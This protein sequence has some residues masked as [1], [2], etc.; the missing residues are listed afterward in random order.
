MSE[1]DVDQ[2]LSKVEGL[3][4]ASRQLRGDIVK[5]LKNGKIYF[6]EET[7][8]ILK[9]H[10][11]YQQDDR[12]LRAARRKAGEEK[13]YSMMIRARI[14]GG[15]LSSQA[16]LQFDRLSQT[17]GNQ[18]L[19]VTTRQTFQIHGV[20]KENI[21]Q[22]IKEINDVMIT[23]LGGCGDQVRNTLLCP[24][25]H[26]GPLH[27]Q[28]K[29]H[30]Y[31]LVDALSA[32]TKAYH[33]IWLDGEK[34]ASG[35]P[36]EE[37]LYGQ[38]YLP[39]KFKLAI[40]IEG[41]NCVD[42]YANDL[43]I[44][45]HRDGDTLLGYTLLVGGGMGRN[46][47]KAD[48]Y[49][50]A[51]SPL[52]FVTPEQLIDA[53]IAIVSIQRDHGNRT[54]RQ[55]SRFKYLIDKVGLPWFKEELERRLGTSLSEPRA[56]HFEGTSD[57]LGW[58]AQGD[59]RFALG[60]FIENGRIIDREGFQIKTALREIMTRFQPE[61]HLTTSQNLILCDL[62]AQD[63]Q[64]IE[65]TLK[66]YGVK[67]TEEITNVRRFSM[68]CPSMPTCGLAIAESERALP[69]LISQIEQVVAELSLQEERFT[70]RMTGCPNGCA[71]PYIGDIGLVG[72]APG[73]YDV[74]L[75]G[76]FYGTHLNERFKETV[77]IQEIPGLLRTLLEDFKVHR[78][79]QEMFGDYCARIGIA[80]LQER[81]GIYV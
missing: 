29:E 79:A 63:R 62:E 20:L 38:T 72:R 5:E 31:Q 47:T 67:L 25:P 53:A 23:T 65:A 56:L 45:A 36:D 7:I 11:M 51:A 41:D 64:E 1:Q 55:H 70:I 74:Y 28:L 6:T 14:P 24:F 10:G 78:T 59:G 32:K 61:I 35:E 77:P 46:H 48:T 44:V 18:T 50:R 68:A 42:V 9:F 57:H 33:E 40:A 26:H 21:K 39:R 60:I 34:I 27:D 3:K 73:K 54:D 15:I 76:D 49:A 22:T 4:V 8:Q 2:Q 81:F 52:C 66:K 75:A 71:R 30:L 13:A 58:Q 19:R 37:P 43:G 17:Y 69:D 16:Y 80:T 12:D